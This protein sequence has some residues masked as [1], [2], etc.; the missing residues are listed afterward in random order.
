MK[1]YIPI[2]RDSIDNI[3]SAEGVSPMDYYQGRGFG[4]HYFTPLNEVPSSK[5]LFLFR[6]FPQISVSGERS[7]DVVIYIEIDDE[8]LQQPV[9]E[10]E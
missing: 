9:A 1:Y 4:Y 8:K 7:E 6:R 3:I 2:H 10:F 5:E